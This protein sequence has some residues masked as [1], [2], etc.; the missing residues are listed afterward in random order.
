M[1]VRGADDGSRR[2]LDLDGHDAYVV[3]EIGP[4]AADGQI[5][6]AY[7]RAM[8]R[9]HP[10]TG[11]TAERAKL[12]NC[13]YDVLTRHRAEYDRYRSDLR[14]G[15][16]SGLAAD[17]RAARAEAAT[18]DVRV[19]RVGPDGAVRFSWPGVGDFRSARS[20]SGSGSASGSGAPGRPSE[21]FGRRPSQ[22]R[23][24]DRFSLPDD[25][26]SLPDDPFS[27]PDDHS[28]GTD[29]YFGSSAGGRVDDPRSRA[30]AGRD[31]SRFS[32][33]AQFAAFAAA[34]QSAVP[35]ARNRIRPAARLRFR[36]SE[37]PAARPPSRPGTQAGAQNGFGQPR[38]RSG[39][40]RPLGTVLVVLG[41]V[42][43]AAVAMVGVWRLSSDGQGASPAVE[44]WTTSQLSASRLPALPPPAPSP[45]TP[46]AA[47][48]TASVPAAGS[49]RAGSTGSTATARALT[50]PGHRCE[51]RPDSSLWCSGSNKHGELG[52]GTTA[53]RADPVR[54]GSPD[55]QWLAVVIGP[56]DT[57]ALQRDNGLWCWGDNTFGQLGY[58]GFLPR[59]RPAQVVQGSGWLA[60]ALD[61]HACA[62][63]I[64]HT[65]WCWGANARHEL[66]DGTTTNRPAPQRIGS[67]TSWAAVTVAPGITCGTRQNG[68]RM[69]WGQ[70]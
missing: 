29:D 2:I 36:S 41:L 46:G 39:R 21:P 45:V 31:G 42:L 19:T 13:A 40:V 66:N 16:I 6:A 57:C 56:N 64:D 70:G 33:G 28:A 54:V 27:L 15:R 22:G 1:A 7:R 11:G 67:E 5:L 47:V 51:L 69:C 25:P 37:R 34:A 49:A 10:D 20:G 3:L 63:R 59:S 8:S 26:F 30:G 65:L 52:D 68:T 62:V 12:V 55:A 61:S 18:D 48:P 23:D 17:P 24:D 44:P 58:G 60:V 32:A 38:A 14:D 43:I 35:R 53:D 9:A 50:P 4:D